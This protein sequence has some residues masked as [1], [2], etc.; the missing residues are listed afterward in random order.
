MSWNRPG[1]GWM[2][3]TELIYL[4]NS[5]WWKRKKASFETKLCAIIDLMRAH[6]N[7]NIM[8]VF[9]AASAKLVFITGGLTK[10]L[11]TLD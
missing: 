2:S 10:K 11:Q 1:E 8:S 9:K 5:F 3:K 6:I 4:I 7:E